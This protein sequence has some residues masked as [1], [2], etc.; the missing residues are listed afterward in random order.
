MQISSFSSLIEKI[1]GCHWEKECGEIPE[2]GEIPGNLE[3]MIVARIERENPSLQK[4]LTIQ[5]KAKVQ[6]CQKTKRTGKDSGYLSV[7]CSCRRH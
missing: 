4:G 5:M 1:G 3:C 6:T 2:R 7:R